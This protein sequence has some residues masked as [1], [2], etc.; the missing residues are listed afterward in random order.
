MMS[1]QQLLIP[2]TGNELPTQTSATIS[3]GSDGLSRVT[4]VAS[5]LE[6]ALT[7]ES[8]ALVWNLPLPSTT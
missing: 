7:W 8:I 3:L 4:K 2:P 5:V 6:R 1:H